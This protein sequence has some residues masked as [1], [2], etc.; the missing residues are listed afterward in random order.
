MVVERHR[1]YSLNALLE[2]VGDSWL[3]AEAKGRRVG[4]LR[5]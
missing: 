2:G 4:F 1:S 5:L 3:K